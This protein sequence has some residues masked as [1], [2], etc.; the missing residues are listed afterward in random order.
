MSNTFP[1]KR[2]AA[3]VWIC[4]MAFLLALGGCEKPDNTPPANATNFTATA[5]DGQALL[6]WTNPGD[7]DLAGVTLVRKEGAYPA[8]VTDGLVVYDGLAQTKTDTGL[9]NGTTYNYA[10]F[11]Y[12]EVPNH[13]SGVHAA[14]LPTAASA[15]LEVLDEL[16]FATERLGAVP[17]AV[18]DAG[19]RGILSTLL[20]EAET[21]YRQGDLCGAL[22]NLKL[23]LDAAQSYRQGPAT[24]TAEQLYNGARN[25]RYHMVALAEVKDLCD[26]TDRVG[27]ETEP[28]V[29]PLANDTA[30]L[31]TA[32]HFGEPLFIT[33][34]EGGETFTDVR[35]PGTESEMGPEGTP[36]V[37]MFRRLVAVPEG[38]QIQVAIDEVKTAETIQLNLYPYQPPAFPNVVSTPQPFAKD[39]GAYYGKSLFPEQSVRTLDVGYSRDVH[40]VLVEVAAGKYDTD[41]QSLTLYRDINISVVFPGSAGNFTTVAATSGFEAA[42]FAS[43]M[44]IN[45]DAILANLRPRPFPP[46]TLGEELLILTHPNFHAAA[47]TLATW[48]NTKGV[49]TNVFNV[50]D[51]AGPG[52]DTANEIDQFIESRYANNM[53]R[54]SYI[55][56]LGDSE[57][58]PCYQYPAHFAASVVKCNTIGSDWG[59]ADYSGSGSD[60]MPDFAVGRIPVDTLAQ[61][62]DVVNK[63]VQYE[64]TPPDNPA[65]YSSAAVA[66]YFQCCV[67]DTAVPPG[68]EQMGFIS[69]TEF[70]VARLRAHGYTVERLYAETTD[71]PLYTRNT[72]PR[73]LRGGA[74]TMPTDIAPT[75]GFAWTGGTTA[76][77]NAFNTGRSLMMYVDHGWNDGWWRP[78][79]TSTDVDALHNGALLPFVMSLACLNGIFDNEVDPS[80]T[81]TDMTGTTTSGVYFAER[82]LRKSD[83]GAI[84]I[85]A[86]TRVSMLAVYLHLQKGYLN[87]IVDATPSLIIGDGYTAHPKRR[88]GDVLNSGKFYMV[89]QCSPYPTY[90]PFMWDSLYT[91]SLIGD[92]SCDVWTSNPYAI[93]MPTDISVGLDLGTGDLLV[94]YAKDFAQIT[95]FQNGTPL[96]RGVVF[97]G[98]AHVKMLSAGPNPSIPI[99]LVVW[100]PNAASLTLTA[101]LP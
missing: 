84:G 41:T 56:L 3:V 21:H 33:R 66:S 92:P 29:D 7:S 25:M 13:S 42:P 55:L 83:G 20:G 36:S 43:N 78:Y 45:H 95:A 64:Q 18:L 87:A 32:I 97:E 63:I 58:I 57:Y 34:I 93:P 69:D 2:A 88:Q 77:A 35:I 37:P 94:H 38:G 59:Y 90:H 68:A 22:Q 10:L 28:E 17:D 39:A 27:F 49:I 73:S 99:D 44:V 81:G 24:D 70:D 14:A 11:S 23:Y 4:A 100:F 50:N 101:S 62:N 19:Q 60:R 76:V 48:K 80:V 6:A 72:T 40:L 85:L 82:L 96:G 53:I 79:F 61:A 65:F 52:P 74:E 51:G 91:F 1:P 71:D 98:T 15:R 9:T 30:Q 75:S 31:K 86:A 16:A 89:S 54:P 12:D 47:V 67:V 5:G 8:D 26:G 46:N